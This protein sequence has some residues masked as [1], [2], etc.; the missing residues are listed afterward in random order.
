MRAQVKGTAYT[1]LV[2][3]KVKKQLR[4]LGTHGTRL[5]RA[6]NAPTPRTDRT[7]LLDQGTSFKESRAR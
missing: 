7:F 1:S 4:E 3:A 2:E 5:D 6:G